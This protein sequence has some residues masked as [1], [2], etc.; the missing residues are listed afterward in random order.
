VETRQQV[1]LK[2]NTI[3]ESLSDKY[4]GL[5]ALVGADRSDSFQ[6]LVGRM[7]QHINGWNEKLF[8]MGG[9]EILLKA[10]AQSTSVSHN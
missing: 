4:L 3:V 8:S 2:L 5:P 6:H 10:C 1:C 7:N 9:K